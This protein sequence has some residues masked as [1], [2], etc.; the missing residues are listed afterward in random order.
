MH[1]I[2][3][4][5]EM[6]LTLF[7]VYTCKSE[8]LSAEFCVVYRCSV[9]CFSETSFY[10]VM[11]NIIMHISYTFGMLLRNINVSVSLN[12]DVILL[13]ITIREKYFFLLTRGFITHT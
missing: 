9:R 10:F 12:S 5:G 6:W 13:S 2:S 8:R 11:L 4:N 1:V 7:N 3:V